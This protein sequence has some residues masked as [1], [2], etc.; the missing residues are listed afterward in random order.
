MLER[1][2]KIKCVISCP[3]DVYAGYGERAYDF[4]RQLIRL[5]PDWD[6]KILSQRWGNCRMGFLKDHGEQDLINRI[7]PRLTEEPDIWIQI[8]VP[9]EF[10][11]MGKYSIGITA[12]M[13]TTACDASWIQG[14][15]RMNL[16]L[17][18]ST[19]GKASLLNSK[20][21]NTQTGGT[22]EVMV[23]VE[24]L[25]EGID[26]NTFFKVS[27]TSAPDLFA[28]STLPKYNFLCVGHWM[29]GDYGQDR[30]NIA[31][32]I[33]M[34]LETFKNQNPRPGLILKTCRATSSTVDKQEI[35]NRIYTIRE[36]V[37]AEDPKACLPEI[38]LLH[39]DLSDEEMN[40]LYNTLNVKALVSF[41][42]G[43][44]FGRPLLEFA[45]IG[46]PVL[47]SG[48]SGPLDFLDKEYS[49]LVGG[50]LE[51]VHPSA[52]VRDMILTEASWFTPND[53]EVKIGFRELYYNYS[54][55]L[56]LAKKYSKIVNTNFNL[57]KMG[58]K[59]EE[60]FDKYL[61]NFPEE[62]K[63]NTVTE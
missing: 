3:I 60:I 36:A 53:Q 50:R 10:Q 28:D 59:I 44:G 21:T 56:G 52:A 62:V 43:E 11:A 8:T 20:Y 47:C 48:W 17:T 30:K 39:G 32:T 4:T 61:P 29:Q 16:V 13:E 51:N 49:A 14:C 31:Y 2:T 27:E 9:N 33:R 54:K 5:K 41:T 45:A 22:L 35:L 18:S 42:K 46:K 57:E 55:W 15:N 12:A 19:H 63:L 7:I 6:I 1:N 26:T 37:L 58:V 24:V 38:F 23:P 25:F 40:Y 34:F